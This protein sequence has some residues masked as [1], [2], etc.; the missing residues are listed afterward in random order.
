[1]SYLKSKLYCQTNIK[2]VK[3]S[4]KAAVNSFM[5]VYSLAKQLI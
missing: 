1:M 2:E 5:K 3:D 4:L